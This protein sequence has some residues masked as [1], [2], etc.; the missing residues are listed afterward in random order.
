MQNTNTL[1]TISP[2]QAFLKQWG[3]T[4]F[5]SLTVIVIIIWQYI[6]DAQVTEAVLASTIRQS[7]PLVLG[8]LCGLLGERSAVIN[9]GIEGQMLL[10]AFM[11]FLVNVWTGNL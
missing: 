10:G 8:A 3:T 4:I 1:P 2:R 9:I 11:G 7:T 5:V 6:L